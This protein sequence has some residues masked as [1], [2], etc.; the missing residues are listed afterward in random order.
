MMI[1]HFVYSNFYLKV[2]FQIRN[3]LPTE[4]LYFLQFSTQVCLKYG[5][6]YCAF[7]CLYSKLLHLYN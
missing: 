1:T 4:K 5:L 3:I 6:N 2:G 7:N